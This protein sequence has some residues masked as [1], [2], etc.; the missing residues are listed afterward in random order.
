MPKYQLDTGTTQKFQT[1]FDNLK[2]T[3]I[4]PFQPQQVLKYHINTG[5]S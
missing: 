4:N 1:T 2:L 5:K 3:Q